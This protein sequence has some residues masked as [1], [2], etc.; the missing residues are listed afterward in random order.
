MHSIIEE[1]KDQIRCYISGINDPVKRVEKS[2]K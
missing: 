1:W 2:I